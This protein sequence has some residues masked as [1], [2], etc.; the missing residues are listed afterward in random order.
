MYR[1]GYV[2]YEYLTDI[3]QFTFAVA[4]NYL[5]DV[6]MCFKGAK[7]GYSFLVEIL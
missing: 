2:L 3:K 1:Y 7:S 4:V 6:L 5:V